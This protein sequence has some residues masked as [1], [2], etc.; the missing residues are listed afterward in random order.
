MSK[1]WPTRP[2][3][4]CSSPTTCAAAL[5]ARLAERAPRSERG[6]RF[7]VIYIDGKQVNRQLN[8]LMGSR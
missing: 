2:A 5:P 7:E 8:D 4:M 6:E 1:V 3:P